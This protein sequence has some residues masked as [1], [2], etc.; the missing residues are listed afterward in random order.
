[1]S[2]I[3]NA[4]C[5]REVKCSIVLAKVTFNKKKTLFTSKLGLNLRRKLVKCYTGA[6]LCMVLK[7]GHL[8][9]VDQKYVG[10][11]ETC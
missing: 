9:E 2:H 8:G 7:H 10:S 1:V 6:V 11:F 5:A 3:W 4:K